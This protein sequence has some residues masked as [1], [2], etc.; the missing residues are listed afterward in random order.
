MALFEYLVISKNFCIAQF[1]DR[2]NIDGLAS[3]RNLMENFD[4]SLAVCPS[5]FNKLRYTVRTAQ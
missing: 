1:I 5:K 3:F 2:G 4:G